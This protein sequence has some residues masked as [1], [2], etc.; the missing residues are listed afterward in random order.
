[1]EF[2]EYYSILKNRLIVLLTNQITTNSKIQNEESITFRKK[3]YPNLLNSIDR[4]SSFSALK[5][6]S[7]L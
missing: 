1:M 7:R 3:V 2:Y 4:Y 6:K 5:Q